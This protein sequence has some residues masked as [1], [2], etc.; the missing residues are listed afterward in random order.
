MEEHFEDAEQPR[1][2]AGPDPLA[3]RGS[4]E[5]DPG[6]GSEREAEEDVLEDDER[7]A[8]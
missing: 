4:G 7:E 1:K 8:G 3:G 5:E 6:Y 2:D